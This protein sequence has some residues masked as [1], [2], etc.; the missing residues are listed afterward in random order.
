MWIEL[1]TRSSGDA[2]ISTQV[3]RGLANRLRPCAAG[4]KTCMACGP[5]KLFEALRLGIALPR[6]ALS[7]LE[8][9]SSRPLPTLTPPGTGASG[10]PR[11]G[12]CT[13][14]SELCRLEG[15]PRPPAA[16]ARLAVRPV[17]FCRAIRAGSY[18][19]NDAHSRCIPDRSRSSRARMR[20]SRLTLAAK[21]GMMQ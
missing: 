16:C 3:G 19:A 12:I 21:A 2:R 18:H 17:C 13:G 10:M 4:M 14:R 15:A 7:R 20:S 5:R 11:A 9:A 1:S 8:F 6:G